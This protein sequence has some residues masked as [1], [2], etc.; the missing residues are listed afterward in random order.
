MFFC[1]KSP[2]VSM[3]KYVSMSKNEQNQK[4]NPMERVIS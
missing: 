3:L 4:R 1:Q 2:Y